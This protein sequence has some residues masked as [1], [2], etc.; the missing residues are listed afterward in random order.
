MILSH[1]S[2]QL[3]GSNSIH[4]SLPNLENL[5]ISP[6]RRSYLRRLR[7]LRAHERTNHSPAAY[8]LSRSR[9]YHREQKRGVLSRF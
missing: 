6:R 1:I 5:S 4:P 2:L 9:L 8:L 7:P 3:S